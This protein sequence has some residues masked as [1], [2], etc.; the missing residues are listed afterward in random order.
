M[1]EEFDE[2]EPDEM[3]FVGLSQPP[4]EKDDKTINN[5]EEGTSDAARVLKTKDLDEIE[6]V[7]TSEVS[8][9]GSK[10]KL[11]ELSNAVDKD[12]ISTFSSV[13]TLANRMEKIDDDD[14][15]VA[16]LDENLDH[17]KKKRLD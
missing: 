13:H 11:S 16:M 1:R 14:D 6:L 5:G 17:S 4:T 10:R 7:P 8:L 9:V 3:I 2:N 12:V 15:D